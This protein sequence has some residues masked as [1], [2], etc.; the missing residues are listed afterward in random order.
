MAERESAFEVRLELDGPATHVPGAIRE[1]SRKQICEALLPCWI[2][3]IDCLRFG[4]GHKR[5]TGRKRITPHVRVAAPASVSTLQSEHR[6][7]RSVDLVHR[8]PGMCEAGKLHGVI[9]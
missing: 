4:Q 9:F 3:H 6:S 2:A 7:R 1:L 5:S 8:R